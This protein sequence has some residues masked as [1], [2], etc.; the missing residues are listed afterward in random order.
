MGEVIRTIDPYSMYFPFFFGH[1]FCVT[2]HQVTYKDLKY[3][4]R[5]P[6]K[7]IAV[8][9]ENHYLNSNNNVIGLRKYEEDDHE[10]KK[11]TLL[12][13]HLAKPEIK[14]V[15]REIRKLGGYEH[16]LDNYY[17]ELQEKIQNIQK[18]QNFFSF[19]K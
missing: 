13:N 2:K 17:D 15:R 1:E 5:K 14:D 16:A 11:L 3:L 9:I 4:N 18:K 8:D 6:N 19:K 12:L 10:L 7:I